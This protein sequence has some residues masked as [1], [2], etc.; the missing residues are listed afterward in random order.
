MH[1]D[2]IVSASLHAITWLT[3]RIYT[4]EYHSDITFFRKYLIYLTRKKEILSD[5][6]N[7]QTKGLTNSIEQSPS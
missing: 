4:G 6:F 7:K 5:N 1:T 3:V 2:T